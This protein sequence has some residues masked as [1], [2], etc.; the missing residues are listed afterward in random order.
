MDEDAEVEGKVGSVEEGG[1]DEEERD[2]GGG[3]EEEEEEG[4]EGVAVLQDCPGVIL[5][6]EEDDRTGK[7]SMDER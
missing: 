3:V 1:D 5:V 6:R 7:R 2:E 4:E